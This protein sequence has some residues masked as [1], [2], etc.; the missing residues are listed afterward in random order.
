MVGYLS[1]TPPLQSDISYSSFMTY[2]R[3]EALLLHSFTLRP[4]EN[5]GLLYGR[6]PF[7]SA[8]SSHLIL[9][10]PTFI[11]LPGLF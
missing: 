1:A 10:L 8:S 5:L 11:L 4:P 9:G 6:L 7:F 2:A 3:D